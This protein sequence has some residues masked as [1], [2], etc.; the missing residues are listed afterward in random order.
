MGLTA[1]ALLQD[2]VMGWL[3]RQAGI[4][5]AT[6]SVRTFR[7]PTLKVLPTPEHR[8]QEPSLRES[9][10]SPPPYAFN[11]WVISEHGLASLV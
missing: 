3:H 10:E 7:S 1:W 4:P 9:G 6:P 11:F 5:G 8:S 2:G